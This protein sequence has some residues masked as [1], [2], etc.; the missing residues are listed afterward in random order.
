MTG[1]AAVVLAAG[2]GK[3]LKSSL[4]KVLHPA[5]GRPL[6]VHVMAALEDLEL[7]RRLVVVNP[8]AREDIEAALVGA[9]FTGVELVEQS[10]PRGTGD[11]ARV[12][13]DALGEF[14]GRVLVLSGDTPLIRSET[15]KTLLATEP[16][17]PAT[18][19]TALVADPFGYGRVIRDQARGVGRV[20]EERDANDVE[21]AVTEVNASIYAFDAQRLPALLAELTPDNAQGELY[22]T[23]VPGL[24]KSAGESVG[25]LE[26]PA[27]EILGVNSRSE[28]AAVASLL[29]RRW[30]ER[31]MD[32]GVAIVDPAVTYIDATVSVGRDA[33]IHPF[34]FLEGATTVG[35]GAEI[36]PHARVVDSDIGPGASVTFAVVR[37]SV[38]GAGAS[39]GPYASLRPGTRLEADAR[40]GSFVESKRS[41]I[42]EGSKVNHLAYVGDATVGRDVN[43]GAGTITCNW[44]GREKH[45]TVIEDEVYVGSDTMLV[46][47][48]RL[49]RR[50]AT[51]AGAVVRGD[52]PPEGLAVGAP[53]RVL[54]G[55][56]NRMKPRERGGGSDNEGERSSNRSDPSGHDEN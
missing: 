25:A 49:G 35:E 13:L 16:R 22:L 47:P 10:T 26:A 24:L 8:R 41:V 44:D 51:G 19:L 5:A 37:S 56:G 7:D 50:S 21:R 54:A 29:R 1:A 42:G 38:L 43:I 18:L 34:T 12:A 40:L 33:V 45:E 3:R 55:R 46:A 32:E 15:L 14:T 48:V 52:V 53:A 11:A 28:L 39:A 2:E 36:G 27:E 9:G 20:V 4:P 30:C 31:L 17:G 23:D 6:L